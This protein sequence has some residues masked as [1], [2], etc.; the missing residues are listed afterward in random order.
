MGGPERARAGLSWKK[1]RPS[2]ACPSGANN[3]ASSQRR[4][5]SS[6][7]QLD[8]IAANIF[9]LEHRREQLHRQ[10]SDVELRLRGERARYNAL[11]NTRA[12]ISKIP[13]DLLSSIFLLCQAAGRPKPYYSFAVA[14]SHVTR[15]WRTVSLSTPLLWNDVRINIQ[16]LSALN[17]LEAHLERSDDC[18]LDLYIQASIPNIKPVMDLISLHSQRWRRLSITTDNDQVSALLTS[19]SS[20]LTPLLEHLSLQI[21]IPEEHHSPRSKYPSSC[22]KILISGAPLLTFVRLGGLALGNLAPPSDRI[23]TL[24]MDGFERYYMEPSQLVALLETLPLLVNLSLGQLHIHHPRDPFDV[25]KQ[26]TLPLLR[27]LRICGP[28]TSP[29]IML[30]L[31]VL[32]QLEALALHDL[33]GFH[34]PSLPFVKELLIDSCAF[35]EIATTNLLHACPSITALAIDFH[36]PIVWSAMTILG[37]MADDEVAWPSVHTLTVREMEVSDVARFRIM[38]STRFSANRGLRKLRVD[39]RTRVVLKSKHCLDWFREHM[40]VE[41][42]DHPAAWPGHEL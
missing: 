23:T 27:S 1:E 24:D 4:H 9:T 30:S 31:L 11:L 38:A 21:E 15:H 29:H 35:D 33:D 32:P 36:C 28:C 13:F 42:C 7:E 17:R 10:L 26:I 18:F 37:D 5:M 6:P 34:A 40:T 14:A 22:P 3:A 12:S 19:L 20:P 16:S 39:R 2:L 41:N 25:T 8:S